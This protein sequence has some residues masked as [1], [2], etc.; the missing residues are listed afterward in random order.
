M[1]NLDKRALRAGS[2]VKNNGT[3]LRTVNILRFKYNKLTG[4]Q[5]VLEDGG[6]AEDEFLDSINFLAEEGYIHLRQISTK[7][8]A[9]LSDANYTALE[10]KL[11]GKGIRLLAGGC[12]DDMIEV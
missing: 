11:T 5:G 4:V 12:S 7:E 9:A 10:A 6:I 2:F 3:V 1:S 8:S